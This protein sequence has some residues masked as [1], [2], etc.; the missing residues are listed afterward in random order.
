MRAES[1]AAMPAI[2]AD[3]LYKA[4]PIYKRP[5]HRLLQ[6]LW[7]G[8]SR[9]WYHEFHALNDVNLTVSRG[10][11]V[12]IVGRNG[13]G[14]STLLQIICGT[15]APSSGQL[16]VRFLEI[17]VLVGFLFIIMVQ[18]LIMRLEDLEGYL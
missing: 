8:D 7:P 5:H 14:K 4:F 10:E 13:S 16:E 2:Q 11:T 3:G 18:I 6:M 9:R 17:D 1:F 15:L 12:G